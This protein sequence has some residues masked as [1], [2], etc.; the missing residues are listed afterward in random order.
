MSTCPYE[1]KLCSNLKYDFII[2]QSCYIVIFLNSLWIKIW[3]RPKSQITTNYILLDFII[4]INSFIL[5]TWYQLLFDELLTDSSK[6]KSHRQKRKVLIFGSKLLWFFFL[7]QYFFSSG[8]STKYSAVFKKSALIKI[9]AV[10]LEA[11]LVFWCCWYWQFCFYFSRFSRCDLTNFFSLCFF[12][13]V[14][15]KFALPS[16]L[17][18]LAALLKLAPN[19]SS[20]DSNLERAVNFREYRTSEKFQK[21]PNGKSRRKNP[22]KRR[23]IREHANVRRQ[24]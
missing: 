8:C 6:S 14:L 20:E 18:L 17:K 15:R 4:N 24:G 9:V 12:S 5:L 11:D 7:R 3:C 10:V 2:A 21:T 23:G 22:S 16:S 1:H 13:F 19:F